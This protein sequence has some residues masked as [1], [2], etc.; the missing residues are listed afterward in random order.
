M[1]KKRSLLRCLILGA[2][3]F[4]ATH[5]FYHDIYVARI[6]TAI[7]I[8]LNAFSSVLFSSYLYFVLEK[9]LTDKNRILFLLLTLLQGL[10]HGIFIVMNWGSFLFL[11]LSVLLI[12]SLF[13]LKIKSEKK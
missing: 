7:C 5:P 11:P 1:K 9:R 6:H 3:L 13:Y 4:L 8:F 2:V 12:F 10:F